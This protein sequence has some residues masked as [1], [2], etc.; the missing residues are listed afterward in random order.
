MLVHM[1][2]SEV[3]SLQ[4]LAMKNGGSLTINPDTGLPE[5]GW[6][7]KL[8]PMIAGAALNFFAPG[9][10]TAI[11]GALGLSGAAGAGIAVGGLTSLATGSLSKGLMAGLGAYGGAGL[12][13]A[14]TGVGAGAGLSNAMGGA[15]YGNA[16]QAFGDVAAT[17]GSA[18][19]AFNEYLKSGAN[20]ATMSGADTLAA[21]A[22]AVANDPMAFAKDNW[23][24]GLAAASPFIADAMVPTTVKA[25]EGAS[26]YNG[27]IR[28]F[29]FNENTRTVAAQTPVLASEWGARGFPDYIRRGQNASPTGMAQGGIVALAEGG[30]FFGDKT[31]V[32][33]STNAAETVAKAVQEALADQQAQQAQQQAQQRAQAGSYD[34]YNTLSGQSKDAY[35]YL[36]G[37]TQSSTGRLPVTGTETTGT[38]TGTGT[39]TGTGTGTGTPTETLPVT[40]SGVGMPG[41]GGGFGGGGGGIGSTGNSDGSASTT[42]GPSIGTSGGLSGTSIGNSAIGAMIGNIANAMEGVNLANMNA[43]NNVAMVD[44]SQMSQAALAQAQANAIAAEAQAQAD[45]AAANAD[46]ATAAANAVADG[47]GSSGMGEGSVAGNAAADG[48]GS[49][50]MGVGI[51]EGSVGTSAGDG[52][53]SGDG[54]GG[55]GSSGDGGGGSPGSAGAYAMGGMLPRYAL[56]GLG[57]LGGYSDGGRLLKGPGDGVSDSIP[58]TIGRKQQP[59]RLADGEFVIPAR[60]V[61]EL[62]NGSTDAG[63]R[64]LYAMMDRIQKNRSKTVGKGKVAANSRAYKHLPA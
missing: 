58:A 15:S 5:A 34:Q 48:V 33:G 47:V 8:L 20:P 23:K 12:A 26:G 53:S 40:D 42:G 3:A 25:P 41:G 31:Y 24:Y 19:Q 35:D 2:P 61:S 59:A 38:G 64:K 21:G 55:G 17:E 18:G 10:G 6:L 14:F 57:S 36:M 45:A 56:G 52:A 60:I 4:T 7:K 54:G 30:N 62:G 37:N 32:G 1:T 44:M 16:A 50:G 13:D 11:G 51:G 22:K 63:A 28:P 29:Q 9:V 27:Y 46:A 39:E 49:S 43:N